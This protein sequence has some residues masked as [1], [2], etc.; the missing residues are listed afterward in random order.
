MKSIG[1]SGYFSWQKA[2][3]APRIKAN[4]NT[5]PNH[6]SPFRFMVIVLQSVVE[7]D[8]ELKPFPRRH[9]P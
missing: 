8:L 1:R 7:S 4:A 6:F 3:D 5:N 9:A 2:G